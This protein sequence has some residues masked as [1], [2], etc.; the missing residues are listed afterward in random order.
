MDILIAEDFCKLLLFAAFVAH[1][2]DVELQDVQIFCISCSFL[3][4]VPFPRRISKSSFT[5][6]QFFAQ[7][8]LVTYW[9]AQALVTEA[10]PELV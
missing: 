2:V 5:S 4:F 1:P 7:A 10:T 3:S 8:S 6:S 9:L